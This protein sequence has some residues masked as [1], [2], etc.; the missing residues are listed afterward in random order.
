MLTNTILRQLFLCPTAAS[1]PSPLLTHLVA[2]SPITQRHH[3]A[4]HT[5]PASQPQTQSGVL[6]YLHFLEFKFLTLQ[7]DVL[8]LG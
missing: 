3:A 7:D 5:P 6:K 1:V 8:S 2:M 4:V